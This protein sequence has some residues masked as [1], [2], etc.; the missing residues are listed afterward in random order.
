ML[1]AALVVVVLLVAGL[2]AYVRLS[3]NPPARWHVDPVTAGVAGLK[4][5]YL[6]RPAGGDGAAPAGSRT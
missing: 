1:R 3:P 2:M 5:G 4:N 6:L